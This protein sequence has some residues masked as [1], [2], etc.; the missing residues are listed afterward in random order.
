[1][2]NILRL[3]HP[4]YGVVKMMAT[5]SHG[6]TEEVLKMIEKWKH[7]YGRKFLT[8]TTEWDKPVTKIY[9]SND[10]TYKEA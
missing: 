2:A 5:T 1:M 10:F 3:I 4:V 6:D 7:L 8:C 9:I